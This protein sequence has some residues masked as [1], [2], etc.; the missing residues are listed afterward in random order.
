MYVSSPAVGVAHFLGTSTG[1]GCDG[2]PGPSAAIGLLSSPEARSF[3]FFMEKTLAGFQTFFKDDLWNTHVPQVASSADCI[4]HA[5]VALASYHE[6][7]QPESKFGLRN[8]NLAIK[9]LLTE[10]SPHILILSCLIFIC[11]EILQGRTQSAIGLFKYGCGIIQSRTGQR[12]TDELAE[13]F[14]RRLGVQISMLVGDVDFE[15]PLLTCRPREFDSLTE[16]REA[17]LDIILDQASPGLKGQ[18][19]CILAKHAAKLEQ[20]GRSFDALQNVYD[21]RAV[22]LLQLYRRDLEVNLARYT[23]GD[24]FFWDHSVVEFEEIIHHAAVA[25]GAS[26]FHMDMGV[27][28]ILFSVVARCRNPQVRQK[29]MAVLA[30]QAQEGVWNGTLTA[31]VAGRPIELESAGVEARIRT[32]RVHLGERAARIVYGWDN[33]FTE[34]TMEW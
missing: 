16:A 19:P 14:L 20:W 22:A 29:A 27:S 1:R 31:K 8:Y 34:E 18:A 24:P 17:L 30:G 26:S 3:Q 7:H 5:V 4:R 13:A 10:S 6:Q 15:L 11:I 12:R 25:G 21:T 32:V 9:G 28:P 2:Y 33:E 23:R